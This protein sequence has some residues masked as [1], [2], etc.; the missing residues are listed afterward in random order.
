MKLLPQGGK[1]GK[2]YP[3]YFERPTSCGR[4]RQGMDKVYRRCCGIDVHKDMV[5]VCV[6]AAVGESGAVKRKRFKTFRSDLIQMRKW[7]KLSKVTEIAM[8]STGVYWRPLWN[9]LQDEGFERLLLANPAQV[10]ALHGRKSD[11]RDAQRIAEF[12]QDN[13]LDGSFVPSAEMQNLRLLLRQRISLVQERNEA[14]NQIRDLFETASVKLSSVL[15][16]LLGVTGRGIIEALIAGETSADKLSWKVRGSLRKK[17]KEVKESLKGCFNETHRLVLA[18]LYKKHQFLTEEIAHFEKLIEERMAPYAEKV[19]RLDGISGVDRLVAWH[20]IAE[21]GVDM[22]VFPDADHCASWAG[23]VPGENESAGHSKS[24]RCRKGNRVLR[25]V[26]TQAA[27]AASRCKKGYLR[28]FFRRCKGRSGW[29]K[30]IV[31]TAHKILTIAYCMLR[32]GTPYRDLG[33]DYFDKLN[34]ART[35]KR[36]IE[37]L[38]ALGCEVHVTTAMPVVSELRL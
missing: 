3:F 34:P 16:D 26:L 19:E 12:L 13:R 27:W 8:E 10:K 37:R 7:L 9:V 35:A 32:D 2:E 23:L 18:R 25:R 31:A 6:L 29:A 1:P 22:T 15:S 38:Q 30:A 33:D 11:R 17:E 14:H 28:A 24:N 36:L 4:R 5:E 20:L 21:L